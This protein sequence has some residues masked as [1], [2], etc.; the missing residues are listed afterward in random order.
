[1]NFAFNEEQKSLG[2]TLGQALGDFPELTSP[3]PADGR[4]REVWG[5]LSELGLFS[6]LVPELDGGVGLSLVDVALAIEALGSGLAPPIVASTLIATDIL[7]VYG[8]EEQR[9][10]WLPAIAEGEMKFAIAVLEAGQGYDPDEVQTA[11]AGG[12]VT[13][14]KILVGDAD[15]ADA[16][17]VL[18][19]GDGRPCL[20]VVA[21]DAPGVALR[22][23][24][25]LDPSSGFFE[26]VLDGAAV[27]GDALIAPGA[28]AAAIERLI[29][30]AATVYAGMQIGIAARMLDTTV[31]YVKTRVQFGQPIGAFQAIKHRCADMAVAIEAGRSA[32]YYAFWAVAEDA[33]DRSRAASMAKAYCGESARDVCNQAIQLHGGMGFTWELTLHRFLRRAKVLEHGFG[34]HV[35][36]YERVMATSL[37]TQ[38]PSIAPQA[39]LVD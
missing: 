15:Q 34:N 6:L 2:E 3:D 4:S 37:A 8:T 21:H 22:P 27:T 31:E 5:A 17:L 9:T 23:H 10:R 13:G 11:I 12:A 25:D 7:A 29:D 14:S 30:V 1:M 24:A 20:V 26:L 38:M 16:F 18:A 28:P 35:W 19:R 33:F 32:A 39:A 36:H